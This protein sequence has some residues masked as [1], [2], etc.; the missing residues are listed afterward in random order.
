MAGF[1]FYKHEQSYCVIMEYLPNGSLS[2]YLSTKPECSWEKKTDFALDIAQGMAFLHKMSIV[3]RDLKP[4]NI[5][6]DAHDRAKVT[7]FGLSVIKTNSNTSIAM[8]EAGTAAYMV[9]VKLIDRLLKTLGYHRRI[10]PNL[11]STRSQ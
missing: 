9:M 3:H 11:M 8:S 10:P 6:L 1:G 7:D 4:G 2:T 5:V